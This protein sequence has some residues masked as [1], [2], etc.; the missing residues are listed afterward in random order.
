MIASADFDD[1]LAW[2][3]LSTR[4][5]ATPRISRQDQ[6]LPLV[7]GTPDRSSPPLKEVANRES[8]QPLRHSNFK[9]RMP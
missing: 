3:P 8:Y 9:L 2:P 5:A 1:C 7:A 4:S 6:P